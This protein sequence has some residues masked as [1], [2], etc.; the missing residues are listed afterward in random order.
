M[1]R[2]IIAALSALM[3]LFTSI[4]RSAG[5]PRIVASLWDVDDRASNELIKKFYQGLLGPEHLRPAEVLRQAQIS[6]WK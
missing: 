6:I 1:G 5:A 2:L 3:V 4:S